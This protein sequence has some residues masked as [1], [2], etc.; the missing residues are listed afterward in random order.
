MDIQIET[1]KQQVE[2]AL[3]VVDALAITTKPE[4]EKAV[5]VGTRIKQVAKIITE[6]KEQI[7]KPL[8]ESLK[9]VRALFKPLEDTL[10]KAE[11]ELKTKMLAF[12]E[13]ERRAEEEARKKA[14]EEIKKQQELLKKGEINSMEAG[15]KEI[16]AKMEVEKLKVEKTV[17]SDSGAKATEKFIT[18]YVVVDK[19]KI[20]FVFLEPDMVKIKQ[21]FKDG[22]PVPGVEER[23]KAIISF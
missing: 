2:K 5:E 13:I 14:E 6:R 21:A 17:K 10:D 12:R 23:K 9:S 7:T 8:N 16:E 11:G 3:Q 22:Q 18:E 20:P 1:E 19:T 15:K 4:Y